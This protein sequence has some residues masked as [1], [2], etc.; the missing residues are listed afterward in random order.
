[1]DN[2]IEI[3]RVINIPHKE[4]ETKCLECGRKITLWKNYEGL[5]EVYCCGYRYELQASQ[6][7]FVITKED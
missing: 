2:E 6:I 1:M 7:D 5:E 3:K 4:Y